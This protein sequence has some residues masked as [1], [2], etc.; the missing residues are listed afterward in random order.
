MPNRS[1]ALGIFVVGGTAL[2]T[3]GTFLIG[4]Q[5][6][7][8]THHFEVYTEFTNL[9]GLAKGA[10]VRVS[11]MDAGEIVDIGVPTQPGSKFRLKLRIEQRLHPL[12]RTDSVVTIDTEGVVGDKLLFVHQGGAKAAEAGPLMTLPSK[13]PLDISDLMEKGAGMLTDVNSMMKETVGKLNGAL[14]TVTT[15]VNNTD[16]IVI[17]LKEGRG[18]AGMLLRDEDTAD[19][20]RQTI[21]NTR[22]ATSSLRH[23]STQADAMVSDFQSRRLGQKADDAMVSAK[24][25]AQ[26]IDATSRQLQQTLTAALGPDEQGT[27]AATNIGQSLSNLNL[28]TGNM[29]ED[30]E[31]LKHNLFFRGFFK[32]RGYYNLSNLKP[33]QYRQDKLFSSPA[34]R[35][36][37]FTNDDLFQ[38]GV[39]G[40]EMLSVLGKKRIDGIANQLGDA[41]VSRPV[42]VEGYAPASDQEEQFAISRNRALLVSQYLHTHFHLDPQN[43]G[44]V[45][46]QDQPPSGVQKD[47][48]DGICLVI[49]N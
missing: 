7:A 15:T 41:M 27:N 34:N 37:W 9:D 12:I 29:A 18:T 45:S 33:D 11:G 43:V 47:H 30:T 22:Q 13:E 32:H 20:L 26:N 39:D 42:V 5:H 16:D 1:V 10:K 8:F 23:A 44:F 24:D 38:T 49:L 28:A 31:A 48:W 25:A 40:V 4:N 17:G 21:E 14:D 6:E 19:Q 46:L 3:L 36:Q 2:F 35:R